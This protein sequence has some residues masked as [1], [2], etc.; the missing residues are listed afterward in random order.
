M[1]FLLSA[2]RLPAGTLHRNS[3][4]K[5]NRI[6]RWVESFDSPDAHSLHG[7]VQRLLHLRWRVLATRVNPDVGNRTGA[8]PGGPKPSFDTQPTELHSHYCGNTIP[9]QAV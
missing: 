2:L 3:S 8:P 6:V 1:N 9:N 5:L 7:K 4:K